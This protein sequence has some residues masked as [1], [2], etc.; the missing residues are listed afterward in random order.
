VSYPA[1]LAV[2]LAPLPATIAN[3]VALVA[4]WPG[5]ALA[6]GPELR[7]RARWLRRHAGVAA[8]GSGA[9]SGLLLVTSAHTF[10]RIVPFLVLIGSLAL[11]SEARITDRWRGRSPSGTRGLVPTLF[12]LSLYNGYFGAGAGVMTLTLMLVLVARDLP[13]ANALKNMLVGAGC[14]VSATVFA[15]VGPVPWAQVAPLAVGMFAGSTLG[16]PVARHVPARLLRAV[17]VALGV[18]LAVYLW[19][20]P[21][22]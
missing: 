3:N 18:G 2:G 15:V 16:P 6:S 22:G 13:T 1:L 10:E 14:L 7:G 12:G 17:I 19:L 21:G 20:D 8:A 4:C 5:S 11:W 9:G